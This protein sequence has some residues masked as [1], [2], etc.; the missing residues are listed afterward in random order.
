MRWR[1]RLGKA[2][3]EEL[4]TETIEAAK[5]AGVIKA[6][7]VKRVILGPTVMEKI[8]TQTTVFT[9]QSSDGIGRQRTVR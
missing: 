2:G 9:L 4:L 8:R 3:V 7:R 6:A 5:R 1:K